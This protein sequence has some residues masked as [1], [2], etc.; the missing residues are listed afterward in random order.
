[1]TKD[2]KKAFKLEQ[3][4]KIR[5]TGYGKHNQ[6]LRQVIYLRQKRV[7]FFLDPMLIHASISRNYFLSWQEGN[8]L[9][10]D[11]NDARLQLDCFRRL[12]VIEQKALPARVLE[13]QEQFEFQ[14]ERESTLQSKYAGVLAEYDSLY[15]E[16][17]RVSSKA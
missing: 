2:A 17:Q 1:M 4:H 15:Q 13:V 14:Q 3:K 6:R 9:L 5:T 11:F 8:K 10:N 12:R 7:Q 16:W